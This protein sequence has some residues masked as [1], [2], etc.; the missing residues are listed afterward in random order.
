MRF[1][2]EWAKQEGYSGAH[3]QILQQNIEVIG[4]D[5]FQT[6]NGALEQMEKQNYA[7]GMFGPGSEQQ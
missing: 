3:P 2:I 4:D 7:Y 5:P 6:S 1:E